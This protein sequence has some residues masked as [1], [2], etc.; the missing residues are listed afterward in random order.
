MPNSV[1]ERLNI[2]STNYPLL[3]RKKIPMVEPG[4]EL[5]TSLLVFRN[6]DH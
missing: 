5:G 1:A 3:S 4:I 2:N 6:A